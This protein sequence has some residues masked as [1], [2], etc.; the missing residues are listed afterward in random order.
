M[1]RKNAFL[2]FKQ[3]GFAGLILLLLLPRIA[4][5]Q[6]TTAPAPVKRFIIRIEVPPGFPTLP[7]QLLTV[8]EEN[9]PNPILARRGY[10][11]DNRDNY[12]ELRHVQR[13][14]KDQLN[15]PNV[16]EEFLRSRDLNFILVLSLSAMPLPATGLLL[17]GRLID[18][19]ALQKIVAECVRRHSSR[20]SLDFSSA[21]ATSL[22]SGTINNFGE[23]R[24]QL[25][26]LFAKLLQIP[27]LVM[28]KTA[29]LKTTYRP[30]TAIRF[31]AWIE[32]NAGNESLLGQQ[33]IPRREYG[34]R[35]T[36]IRV[37]G[38]KAA[39]FCRSPE[40]FWPQLI[41]DARQRQKS[42]RY[43]PT[44]DSEVELHEEKTVKD[45][46]PPVSSKINSLITVATA[47]SD[48]NIIL[49]LAAITY[50]QA[51]NSSKNSELIEIESSSLYRCFQVRDLR[52][53]IGLTLRPAGFLHKLSGNDLQSYDRG[54]SIA[55]DISYAH[56][57]S[58]GAFIMRPLY[59]FVASKWTSTCM[60]KGA[61]QGPCGVEQR[62]STLS[63]HE[64]RLRVE[65]RPYAW[66]IGQFGI[67]EPRLLFDVGLGMEHVS[68]EPAH[69]K[70]G[71][72]GVGVLGG[73]IQGTLTFGPHLGGIGKMHL[74]LEWL[75]RI[76]F[77]ASQLPD[78][79]VTDA[80]VQRP[81][82][83]EATGG[84]WI[85]WGGDFG[86]H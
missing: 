67:F 76:P 31:G 1:D 58:D 56:R 61:Q 13:N 83:P 10:I 69:F 82:Q 26:A 59:G 52:H 57:F 84:L 53:Y 6:S 77:N 5:A 14:E 75:A 15:D 49:R 66:Q 65:G 17:T 85:L 28:D 39:E 20:C 43:Q 68:S 63:S 12:K 47:P 72:H 73:G 34:Y 41:S 27:A 16:I 60:A 78:E 11:Y 35:V 25:Q 45:L 64:L 46:P 4:S 51:P 50:E 24:D 19:S 62:V 21:R 2:T 81:D 22:A 55:M 29:P 3:P 37:S 42:Q 23:L 30:W 36:A 32:T 74:G 9:L 38:S 40:Q 7:E 44:L 48:A 70:D 79:G 86:F 54:S 8:V 80:T 18:V 71:W 33:T